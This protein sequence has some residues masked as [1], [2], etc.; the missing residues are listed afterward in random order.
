MAPKG[1]DPLSSKDVEL[2]KTLATFVASSLKINTSEKMA[3]FVVDHVCGTPCICRNLR[4][5]KSVYHC[6]AQMSVYLRKMKG[7]SKS[8]KK[9][10]SG[11]CEKQ[12]Q[13]KLTKFFKSNKG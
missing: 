8:K 5:Y 12:S 2:E 13:P 6:F 4:E 9:P 10:I 7:K 11:E 1:F 3:T